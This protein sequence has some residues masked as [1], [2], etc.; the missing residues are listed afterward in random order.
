[1]NK[2]RIDWFM[3]DVLEVSVEVNEEMLE[4]LVKAAEMY[5]RGGGKPPDWREWS[6]LSEASRMAFLKAAE[7]MRVAV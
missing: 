3:A 2:T 1:M 4:A 5:L 7:N 6:L